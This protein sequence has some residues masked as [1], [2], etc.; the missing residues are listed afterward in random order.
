MA[1]RFSL[2][3]RLLSSVAAL[4][5]TALALSALTPVPADANEHNLSRI[6]HIIVIYQEN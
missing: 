1:L 6:G 5:T 2:A 4:S 3:S